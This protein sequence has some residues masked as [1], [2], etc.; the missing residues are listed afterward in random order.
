MLFFFF[1]EEKH[2][3]LRGFFCSS[4]SNF[5]GLKVLIFCNP[6]FTVLAKHM[7]KVKVIF[8]FSS[9][10]HSDHQDQLQVAMTTVA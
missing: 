3:E 8:S 4:K 1:L 6:D 5:T 9:I 7:N 10:G 2:L